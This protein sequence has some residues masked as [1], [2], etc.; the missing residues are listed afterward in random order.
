M[1]APTIT[2]ELKKEL[3]LFKVCNMVA[4]LSLLSM[5]LDISSAISWYT[6]FS[7]C[8]QRSIFAFN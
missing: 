5:L 2:P 3:Q 7:H 1:P 6:L 8:E 4:L